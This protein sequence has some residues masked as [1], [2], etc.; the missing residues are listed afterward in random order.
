MH[1]L[2]VITAG[3]L[4]RKAGGMA[5]KGDL[6]GAFVLDGRVAVITGAG[7]GLGQETA[8]VLALAG[9]SLMLADIDEAG[10]SDTIKLIEA[11]GGR[12]VARRT[13]VSRPEELDAL[14]E[15]AVAEFGR[16][17]VWVNGAGISFLHALLD[18]DPAQTNPVVAV[19]MMGPYW[20]SIAAARVMRDR[21]GGAIINISSGGGAMP[22]PGI[23]LYGMTKAAVNSLSWTSAAEFGQYGI[24]VNAIAPGWIETPMSSELFRDAAGQVTEQSK[25]A[26][27]D[28]MA[29]RTPLG[30]NGQPSDVALAVLYLASDASRF[31]NGQI[32]TVDGGKL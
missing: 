17:D 10:L 8:R 22:L 28:A 5:L 29:A 32:L 3:H 30:I 24:R 4:E 1:G 9:A 19:N 2:P 14:A 23:G 18:S 27:R 31:V 13:D 21:G 7:S 15:T 16:L 11:G 26:V 20:G 6:A 25:Q 12:A